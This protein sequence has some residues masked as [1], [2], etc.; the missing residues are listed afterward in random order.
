MAWLFFLLHPISAALVVGVPFDT[1]RYLG[2][3]W[4]L[5]SF[6]KSLVTNCL[7]CRSGLPDFLDTM[8]QNNRE[9][10]KTKGEIPK[11]QLNHQMAIQ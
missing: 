5:E 11:L 9:C 10:T 8:Y 2:L 1:S 4:F 6:P 7:M 3:P